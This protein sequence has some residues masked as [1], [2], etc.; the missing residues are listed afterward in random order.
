[1]N[2]QDYRRLISGQSAGL[3]AQL[4]RFILRILAWFYSI[5][6]RVRNILYSR[7]CLKAHRVNSLVIS[8]GNITVGGTG[9]T[10]LVAWLCNRITPNYKCAI[11]TR[12][13]KT[14]A[15]EISDEVAILTESC[16]DVK[17]VVNP[18]RVVGATQ[19]LNEFGAQVLI[20]DDGFQ[21]RRLARDL[22]IVAIDATRPFGYAKI[23]PAGLLREPLTELKRADAL[24]ITRCDQ[25][26]KAELTRLEEKLQRIKPD[27]TI[28]R[29]IHKPI[30]TRSTENHEINLEELKG[31]KIFAFCGIGNPDAFLAT[32]SKLGCELV[33]SKI[34]N[35]HHYYTDDCLSEMHEQASR[36]NADLMLTTQKDW[37]S[38]LAL[39]QPG[40]AFTG[41]KHVPMAYLAIEIKFIA[42]EE[43]ITQLIE[44]ELAGRISNRTPV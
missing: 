30:C 8:I 5:V 18:D 2:Q 14:K 10:P 31:K 33:D 41:Q 29:A 7:K 28:A 32:I 3:G 9:K 37:L 26:A 22:D 21:H 38:G 39:R 4:C 1:M 13:Y 15:G 17:I 43:K 40:N 27:M 25:V 12:G 6:I 36:L 44:N 19:A 20:M 24:V 11:L 16:P 42:G 23:F 35:D 34:Y